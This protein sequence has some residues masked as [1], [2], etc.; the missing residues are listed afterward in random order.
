MEGLTQEDLD[1]IKTNW[2]ILERGAQGAYEWWRA[3]S[4]GGLP[5]GAVLVIAT[6]IKEVER[7]TAA[8]RTARNEGRVDGSNEERR[9][10]S[11]P[12]ERELV[13]LRER[14]ADA[15]RA[16]LGN[17]VEDMPRECEDARDTASYQRG[18]AAG[19]REAAAAVRALGRGE[20]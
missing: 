11:G 8:L 13:A 5:H 1:C 14:L 10:H 19:R 12:A 17:I 18:Y 6:L 15:E 20:A 2:G 7:V 9:L 3:N 4:T 16:A